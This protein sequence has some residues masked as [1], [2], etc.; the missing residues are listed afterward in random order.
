MRRYPAMPTSRPRE[1]AAL[2]SQYLE[3]LP[4]DQMEGEMDYAATGRVRADLLRTSQADEQAEVGSSG[5]KLYSS[6]CWHARI[7]PPFMPIQ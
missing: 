4:E 5:I 1:H 7:P 3:A 2:T 6:N